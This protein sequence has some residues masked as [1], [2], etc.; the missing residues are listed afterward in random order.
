MLP[1]LRADPGGGTAFSKRVKEGTRLF[2]I[3]RG[4]YH[5]IRDVARDRTYFF[6]LESDPEERH[7]LRP[8][9]L[10]EEVEM[11]KSLDA[12]MRPQPSAS[13]AS[14]AA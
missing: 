14:D 5:Y 6:D 4:R 11:A 1:L 3:R 12:W 9:S 7:D 10:P 8:S 13:T 2:S